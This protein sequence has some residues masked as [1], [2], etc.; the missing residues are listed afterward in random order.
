MRA[1]PS[2]HLA[3][4]RE[5]VMTTNFRISIVLPVDKE[6]LFRAWLSSKEHSA[7][8]GGEAKVTS[9]VG[10]KFTAWDGYIQ[11]RTVELEP[12]HRIIQAWRTTDFPDDAPDSILEITIE[13]LQQGSKL[14]LIHKNLPEA[15]VQEYKQGWK[16]HYFSPMKDYFLKKKKVTRRYE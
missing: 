4:D 16:D 12:C 13:E 9:R 8:T 11:G 7:F 3:E 14:T 2:N 15:Q 1:L 6:R 10:G 5:V